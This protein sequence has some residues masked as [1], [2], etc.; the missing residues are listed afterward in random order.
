MGG[1]PLL[2]IALI[3]FRTAINTIE[4]LNSHTFTAFPLRNEI[5]KCKCDG[6]VF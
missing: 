6:I 2:L 4:I 3:R 5:G 1:R